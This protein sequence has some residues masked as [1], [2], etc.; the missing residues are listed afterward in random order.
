MRGLNM[1]NNY[2][3]SLTQKYKSGYI[4]SATIDGQD[5]V[6]YQVDSYAYVIYAKSIRSAKIAI[7]KHTNK[8]RG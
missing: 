8:M 4:Y 7:T 2:S 6:K 3:N 5:V 1:Y